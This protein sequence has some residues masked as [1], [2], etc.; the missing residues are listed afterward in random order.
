[1]PNTLRF[2]LLRPLSPILA[3][4]V[5]AFVAGVCWYGWAHDVLFYGGDLVHFGPLARVSGFLSRPITGGVNFFPPPNPLTSFLFIWLIWFVGLR[6][7]IAAW[8]TQTT[9]MNHSS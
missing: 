3:Y 5:A 2:K 7:L 6:L 9:K 4:V 1:M 8:N